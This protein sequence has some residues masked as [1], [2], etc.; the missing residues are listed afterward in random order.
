MKKEEIL[1]IRKASNNQILKS[2]GEKKK[3][4]KQVGNKLEFEKW[5]FVQTLMEKTLNPDCVRGNE[6]RHF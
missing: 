3:G 5:C 1:K 6:Y 2:E 4:R